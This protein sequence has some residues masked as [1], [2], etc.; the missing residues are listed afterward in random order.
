LRLREGGVSVED[1]RLV[2]LAL[3]HGSCDKM[4]Q[5]SVEL[6]LDD[7]LRVEIRS[8]GECVDEAECSE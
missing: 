2:A 8:S 5:E 3:L 6:V 7:A 1:A 4:H